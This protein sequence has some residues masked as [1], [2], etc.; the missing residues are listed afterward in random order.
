VRLAQ[1]GVPEARWAGPLQSAIEGVARAGGRVRRP[2]ALAVA[3]LAGE[4][5]GLAPGDALVAVLDTVEPALGDDEAAGSAR[6]RLGR[7]AAAGA[8]LAAPAPAA[9]RALEVALGLARG[10]VIAVPLPLPSAGDTAAAAPGP[11]PYV[12]AVR[13]PYEVF[14][15]ALRALWT[16]TGD[17]PYAW[18]A[19][20]DAKPYVDP[21]GLTQVYGLLGGG[22]VGAVADWREVIDAAAVIA[23]FPA[24][25]DAGHEL[26]EALATG[27]PVVAPFSP[28]V[29]DHLRACGAPAFTF[30]GLH[31][32]V[33]MAGALH[34]ALASG[35]GPRVGECA[36]DA[37]LGE[38][39]EPSA[40]R[41]V[42]ALAPRPARSVPRPAPRGDR[43][44]V[45][46]VDVQGSDGGGERLLTEI[47]EGLCRHPSRPDVRLVCVDDPELNFSPPLRRARAAGATVVAVPRDEAAAAARAAIAAADVGWQ[48]WAQ[49]AEP[50]AS[51][52]PVVATIHD[53][54]WRHFDIIGGSD[55]ATAERIVRGWVAE[56]AAVTCS[57][58]AIRDDIV[59]LLPE[60]AGRVIAIPLAAPRGDA[61]PDEGQL[62]AVRRRYA[63]PSRF[64]LSPAPR[65][66]H[67]NYAVLVAALRRLRLAGTPVTVVATGSGTDLA[68]WGPDLVGLGYV[69]AADLAALRA[70]ASGLVQS[71][72][73][74]AGSFPVF[75]A[76]LAGLPVACSSIPAIAEQLARDGGHAALFDPLDP[77]D[78]ARALTAVWRPSPH[79][80]R[81]FYEN[82][83][84]VA[85][86]TWIDVAGDYLELL[87]RVAS[88]GSGA[89]AAARLDP[90]PG[91][92]Q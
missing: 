17:R 4:P 84:R 2:I 1:S 64:L 79:D 25:L 87:A 63:L 9:A 85:R 8:R 77:E 53:V 52:T 39:W 31:D 3:P 50:E 48:I 29:R 54:A 43:L 18:V 71:T 37:V 20:D 78:A 21:G 36:R 34:A 11:E 22:D 65:S 90:A 15:P 16:L 44:A 51:A 60:A 82:A 23:W 30:A 32:P 67:K 73:Y 38:S 83:A 7:W 70:L 14:L 80:L 72:L 45:A 33:G 92:R 49:T 10:A 75:E 89:R 24:A 76:M 81:L 27:R 57:S 56:A 19:A 58:R 69:P 40:M 5:P 59:D 86:R 41:I 6:A 47:V 46:L 12:V 74:E 61:V 26:R 68:Y 88:A 62:A 28:I 91:G 13:P 55:R 42:E 35:R 66:R